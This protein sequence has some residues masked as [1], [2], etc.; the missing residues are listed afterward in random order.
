MMIRTELLERAHNVIDSC[1]A[2]SQL[3]V[4][5][6]YAVLAGMPRIDALR[7]AQ[8]VLGVI[9]MGTFGRGDKR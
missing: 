3:K 4:A 8:I 1:N 7:R 2:Y 9:F 5:V 6:E